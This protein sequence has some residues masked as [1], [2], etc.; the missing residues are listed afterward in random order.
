MND[1]TAVLKETREAIARYQRAGEAL[2]GVVLA[3]AYVVVVEGLPLAFDIEDGEAIN[4]R[5]ADPH[6]ATRFDLENAAHVARLVK[7][8]NG[9]PGE[10]MHVR[11]AIV[12]AILEQE[13][14]L[15]TLEDHTP[16]ASQ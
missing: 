9:T 15:K 7:N 5:T 1:W 11:H 16:K 14:L 13:A 2:R 8:G 4:P 3:Q 12:D 6:Q 10:V